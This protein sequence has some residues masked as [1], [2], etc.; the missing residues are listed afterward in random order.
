MIVYESGG[1]F[2]PSCCRMNL[3]VRLELYCVMDWNIKCLHSAVYYI[4]A[5]I[6]PLL[7]GRK[8]VPLQ[9]TKLLNIPK[10]NALTGN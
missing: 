9:E 2:G 3:I 1:I 6:F 10:S 7:L 5:S 4:A 8:A